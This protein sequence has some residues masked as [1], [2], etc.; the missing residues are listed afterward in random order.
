MRTKLNLQIFSLALLAGGLFLGAGVGR[1]SAATY[2]VSPTGSNTA[3]YDTWAKAATTVSVARNAATQGGDIIEIDG[4]L[5]GLS[6]A[7]IDTSYDNVTFKGSSENEHNG[8]VTINGGASN[9]LFLDKVSIFENLKFINTTLYTI[10][11]TAAGTFNDC[12]IGDA[13]TNKLLYTPTANTFN[14][15]FN[16][17]KIY[18]KPDGNSIFSLSQSTVTT[19]FNACQFFD[20]QDS[21][22]ITNGIVQFNNDL[23]MGNRKHSLIVTSGTGAPNVSIKNSIF[24]GN[25]LDNESSYL[26]NHGATGGGGIT[27]SSSVFSAGATGKSPFAANVIDGGNNKILGVSDY[28]LGFMESRMPAFVSFMNENAE[29]GGYFSEMAE[30]LESLGGKGTWTVATSHMDDAPIY[31]KENGIARWDRARDLYA[32]GHEISS[33]TRNNVNL[34]DMKAFQMSKS[35]VTVTIN[36]AADSI[37]TSDGL[38]KTLSDYETV[39]QLAAA[40]G[41]SYNS[42][43]VPNSDQAGNGSP[44]S[45]ADVVDVDISATTIFYY[46]QSKHF[47]YQIL[48]SKQDIDAELGAG[49]CKTLTVYNNLIGT[50]GKLYAKSVGYTAV[51]GSSIWPYYV[52]MMDPLPNA[53]DLEITRLPSN[54]SKKIFQDVTGNSSYNP[55]IDDV[56]ENLPIGWE[57]KFDNVVARMQTYG[58]VLAF[59]NYRQGKGDIA[60]VELSRAQVRAIMEHLA[61]RGAQLVTMENAAQWVIDNSTGWYDINR[62]ATTGKDDV[63]TVRYIVD[64]KQRQGNYV[65]QDT[66]SAIDSGSSV[67][68]VVDFSGNPIYGVP[69]IGTYEYQPPHTIGINEIDIAAGARIY[70]D[71]KFRDLNTTSSN[72]ADLVIKPE[73]G[74][75]TTYGSTEARPN[76]MD[77][78]DITWLNTGNHRKAWT[79]SSSVLGATNILHTIGDLDSNKNY[80][81]SVDTILGQN[82][83]GA[84]GTICTNGICKSNSEG[85]I[86]FLYTGGYS[87]HDF[88]II[89]GDN[90]APIT[91]VSPE[92]GLYNAIQSVVLTCSDD[93]GVGCDKTYYTLDGSNPTTAST[94]HTDPIDIVSDTVLKFF[95]TDLNGNSESIQTKAYVI[96]T[97]FPIITINQY[98]QEETDQNITVTASTNEGTLNTTTH[99]FT[100]NGSFDFVATDDAGNQTTETVTITNIDKTPKAVADTSPNLFFNDSRKSFSS[101]LKSNRIKLKNTNPEIAGGKIKI[102]NGSKLISEVSVDQSG[103][104]GVK[105]KAKTFKVHYLNQDGVEI[106]TSKEYKLK[107]DDKKPKI[108]PLSP[109]YIKH[110]GSIMD[111]DA[112]DNRGVDYYKISIAGK[113]IKTKKSEFIIPQ[114]SK[115]GPQT[116]TITAYDKVGNKSSKKGNLVVTW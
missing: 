23:F 7:T 58:G 47:E 31:E 72:T 10:N 83:Q 96:D 43:A 67:S 110:R 98:D 106:A 102:K 75:F 114:F 13:L 30:D 109:L 74:N 105:I 33:R 62:V 60:D 108:K 32:R 20:L 28:N 59:G 103:Q 8:Q 95:S 116:F 38:T 69:D 56:A 87:E 70:G 73:S 54:M 41:A 16:R 18:K 37:V 93:A 79:E 89:E 78:T 100:Q 90:V 92:Q 26:I 39:T 34:V 25:Y 15:I 36:T 22:S 80:N 52:V 115:K 82:I 12:I 11:A 97:I 85:K 42:V 19:A 46:D 77:I 61:L 27:V 21:I 84:N 2:Y 86:S 45:L 50:E 53:N 17:S 71:G 111:F 65:L 63:N 94:Q 4:G 6:Y 57:K 55:A 64:S 76:W 68:G 1:A 99:T 113:T 104:W 88:E 51:R 40:I 112:T 91:T 29:Q 9:A 48:G 14:L 3:P 49:A 101:F 107:V 35:G 5:F 44:T 81:V 24:L 66:S